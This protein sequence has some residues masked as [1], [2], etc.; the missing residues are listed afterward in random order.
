MAPDESPETGPGGKLK[1][2]KIVE[3][4]I[5]C[6]R[7]IGTIDEDFHG[8]SIAEGVKGTLIVDLAEVKRISSFG[9]REWVDFIKAVEQNTHSIYFIECSPKII[10]QFNMVAN[11]GGRGKI[12]SFYAP[13]R[14][15]YCDDDRRRLVQVDES[16]ELIKNMSLPDVPCDS[17]GNPE[18]FDE[19]PT[20][21]FTY[22]ASQDAVETDPAVANFLAAKL[23]YRVSDAARRLRADKVVEEATFI[24]LAGD[25]DINFPREKLSEGLEGEVVIDLSAVGRVDDE[26]AV[27]W[28]AFS[29]LVSRECKVYLRDCQPGFVE[30][31]FTADALAGRVEVLSFFMPFKCPSCG[32]SGAQ[33][34]ET[35]EHY[36]VLKFATSP[37]FNCPECGT[38]GPSIASEEFLAT[39]SNLVPPTASKALIEFA[40]R[41]NDKLLKPAAAA[42]QAGY[43]LPV[44]AAPAT[45][46]AVGLATVVAVLVSLAVVGGV[47]WWIYSRLKTEKD[48]IYDEGGRIV[49]KEK[50]PPWFVSWEK[51][52]S[53]KKIEFGLAD[54][55]NVSTEGGKIYVIGYS[56]AAAEREEAEARAREAALERLVHHLADSMKDRLWRQAVLEQYAQERRRLLRDL[57]AAVQKKDGLATNRARKV[58]WDRRIAVTSALQA[59]SRA[60]KKPAEEVY[61]QQLELQQGSSRVTRYRFWVRLAVPVAEAAKLMA[62]YVEPVKIES[63]KVSLLDFFPG[64]A[65]VYDDVK[66][67]AIVLGVEDGS[68]WKD[69]VTPGNLLVTCAEI[70]IKGP[71]KFKEVVD[72]RIDFLKTK[73][74]KVE[75]LS[76][77]PRESRQVGYAVAK[78]EEP[79]PR[80]I[81]RPGTPGMTG[82]GPSNVNTWDDPTQ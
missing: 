51:T 65:W 19:D 32:Y 39:L 76:K 82:T 5:M 26:G 29:Q 21:F 75:C 24:R 62:Q 64:L 12:L 28:T 10:D 34:V 33:R 40:E 20:S 22:L 46:R 6:L 13:Y 2:T 7:F 35:L 17:C 73:G 15:D 58:V 31:V 8:K 3:G 59:G 44:A 80:V 67:G 71:D 25:I 41:A 38:V 55:L 14:C 69:S 61:F 50:K 23:D 9:I 11:F 68:P 74:G 4:D 49:S 70:P 30:K 63:Q 54:E 60:F 77:S 78:V 53:E 79:R 52:L 45:G 43:V 42:Q 37:E 27:E 1:V 66:H 72:E 36:D 16:Q 56:F 48:I 18:Y 57:A 47:G 81:T